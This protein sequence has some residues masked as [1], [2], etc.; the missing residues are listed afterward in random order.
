MTTAGFHQRSPVQNSES[1]L[2]GAFGQ[3][4]FLRDLTMAEPHAL[5]A[6]AERASPEKQVDDKCRR[7]VVVADQVTQQNVCDIFVDAKSRHTCL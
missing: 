3:A 6:I 4:G 2:H 7:T 1:L 5:A